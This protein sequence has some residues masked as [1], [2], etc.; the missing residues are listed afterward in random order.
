MA[1]DEAPSMPPTRVE[2]ADEYLTRHRVL[3]LFNNLT[4]QLIYARPENPK[5]FITDVLT[6]LQK[7][8]STQFDLPCLF[9]ESN[10]ASIFGML[11]PTGR[12]FISHQQYKEALVTLG[13][14]DFDQE[15]I[16]HDVDR[17]NMDTF[18][19]E[20]KDGLVRASATFAENEG[21]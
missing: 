18:V 16:G 17:I 15:P 21:H 20:A 2:E 4:S 3:D 14:K 6:R 11:D 1:A 7:S 9:D 19:R 12:G 5:T 10:I 13:I 8:K